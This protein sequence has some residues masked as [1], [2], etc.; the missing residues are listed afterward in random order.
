MNMWG[1]WAVHFTMGS[2]MAYREL[3]PFESPLM[4]DVP[5][6]YP[7]AANWISAVLIR[8]GVPF[9]LAFTIPSFIFSLTLVAALYFF[10]KAILLRP[11]LAV[12]AASL[13]L[14]NGGVGALIFL[15]D[16]INA[17]DSWS[18]FWN[19]MREYTNHEAHQIKW[20]S[21]V[22]SMV[23]PQRAFTLGFGWALIA[24]TLIFKNF[25]L[26][27]RGGPVRPRKRYSLLAGVLLGLLPIIHT[28][29]F[30]ACFIILSFWM[31][32][33]LVL[34][35]RA[36][37]KARLGDWLLVLG[38]TSV[39][40]LPLI[41][42]FIMSQV[43]NQF[44]KWFPGWYAK[45]WGVNWFLFWFKNWTL[46]PFLAFFAFFVLI[47]R[48]VT[49]NSVAGRNIVG[50]R[51]WH[52]ALVFSPGLFLFI[53]PNLFL[54]QPWIWDNTKVLVW[55][56]V[57]FSCMASLA[58]VLIFGRQGYVHKVLLWFF[59]WLEILFGRSKSLSIIH[60]RDLLEEI[61]TKL[62]DVK[63]CK[64]KELR[65]KVSELST[66]VTEKRSSVA[67]TRANLARTHILNRVLA[68]GVI[69]FML[70]SGVLDAYYTMRVDLHR[71]G[72]YSQVDLALAEWV[73]KSTA[74]DSRWLTS[75]KHNHWLFNLTGRQPLMT[76]TG[77]LW[78]HGYDFYGLEQE[79]RL[80]FKSGDRELLEKYHVD[81]VIVDDHARREMKA[82]ITAFNRQF[83]KIKQLGEN[84]I[85]AISPRA[86]ATF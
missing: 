5:L 31:I 58:L 13:F 81:Y 10:C 82:D 51:K 57:F 70:A 41:Y 12:L 26:L 15:Q 24:L 42:L 48:S 28:H 66:W 53:V 3:I 36:R 11:A 64:S 80:M 52:V 14:F 22:S 34:L 40:A 27:H 19:P 2:S 65:E 69:C 18:A 35:D 75:T 50:R 30:L 54:T 55:S 59:E 61:D 62:H 84:H 32:A 8:C 4:I 37:W 44:L 56:S 16:V 1:D 49:G 67:S 29:S 78:T 73:K 71:F 72:M 86:R 17:P 25:G 21:V 74:A 6:A 7:F 83:R 46:V 63:A 9:F 20:I 68:S 77:W 76:Y 23:I 47:R 39:I 43:G 33:D 38:I 60:S 79:V 45:E 85:Y